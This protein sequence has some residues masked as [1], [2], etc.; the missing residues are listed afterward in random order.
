MPSSI[1][2]AETSLTRSQTIRFTISNGSLL[3]NNVSIF[4]PSLPTRFQAERHW[5]VDSRPGSGSEIVTVAYKTDV[6]PI[7]PSQ[8]LNTLPDRDRSEFYRLKLSLFDLQGRSATQRPVSVCLVRT[9]ARRG[10]ESGIGVET[11]S[12]SGPLQVIQIEE[13]VHRVY[14]HHLHTSQN[15]NPDGTWSWWRMKS[16]KSYFI[17]NN[18]E[19]SKADAAGEADTAPSRLPHLDTTSGMTGKSKGLAR[20]IGNRHSWHLSKLVLVPGFFELAIAI[21]CSVIGYLLGIAIVA[22]YEYFCESDAACD[23]GP[24]LGRPLGDDVLFDSDTEKRRLTIMSSDS[25]DSEAYI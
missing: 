18:R 8:R 19:A 1:E 2:T 13:T 4:P 10:N 20:W 21:L 9:Q 14:H 25:S 3:A 24:D 7:P 22:V 17:S 6:Q 15:R 11:G 23:K 12:E 16:W 5:A